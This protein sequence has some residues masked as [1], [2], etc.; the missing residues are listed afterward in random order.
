[1]TEKEVLE[2]LIKNL[3]DLRDCINTEFDS[4]L[5]LLSERLTIQNRIERGKRGFKYE[6]FDE[7]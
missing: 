3:Q 4:K 2:T 6:T 1:M 7:G 5:D